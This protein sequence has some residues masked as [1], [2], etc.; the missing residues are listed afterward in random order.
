MMHTTLKVK[1]KEPVCFIQFN[2]PEAS[3]RIN[4]QLI[5]EFNHVVDTYE[6]AMTVLVIEGLPEVFSFEG[7][8]DE[9]YQKMAQGE[10]CPNHADDLYDL[11]IR[12]ATGA[13]MTISHVRGKVNASGMGF[14]G[15][16]DMVIADNTAEFSL[17]DMLFGL[18]PASVMPFLTQR[19]GHQRTNYMALTTLPVTAEEAYTWGLVDAYDEKSTVLLRKMLLRLRRLPRKGVLRYK[20]YM[21]QLDTDLLEK[22]KLA[23]DTNREMFADPSSYQ[24]IERFVKEG[25]FPWEL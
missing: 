11:W 2:R 9:M 7:D 24:R 14:I 1:Y 8:F 22:R 3:N 16:S 12:L 23:L 15:A 17:S 4:Q 25:K 19:I 5:E 20:S 18:V 10:T 6:D 21:N 13:Y